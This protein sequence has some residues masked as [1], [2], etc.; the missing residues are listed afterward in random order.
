MFI[1]FFMC[2]C[3]SRVVMVSLWEGDVT[4]R[5]VG[6]MLSIMCLPG[7]DVFFM[8]RRCH[9]EECRLHLPVGGDG[10]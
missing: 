8:G 9:R 10:L 7:G 6:Y 3:V 5:I 4:G 2:I 1:V